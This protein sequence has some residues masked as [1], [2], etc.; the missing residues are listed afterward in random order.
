MENGMGSEMPEQPQ[1]MPKTVSYGRRGADPRVIVGA[2]VAVLLV[3]AF[4]FFFSWTRIRFVQVDGLNILVERLNGHRVETAL[5]SRITDQEE[6]QTS[7]E[8]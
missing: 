2:A 4:L 1:E 6:D 8:E 3:L 7:D 5:V